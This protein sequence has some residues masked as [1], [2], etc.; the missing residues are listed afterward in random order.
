MQW[1]SVCTNQVDHA[2]QFTDSSTLF[3]TNVPAGYSAGD[4]LVVYKPDGLSKWKWEKKTI[5][6]NT[7][8]FPSH[9]K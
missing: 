4:H 5:V 7:Y 3:E 2:E 8:K 6:Q 1:V 9:K